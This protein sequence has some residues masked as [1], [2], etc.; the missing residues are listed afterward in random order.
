MQKRREKRETGLTPIGRRL[1]EIEIQNEVS[2][3]QSPTFA[4]KFDGV[5]LVEATESARLDAVKRTQ[6][7]IEAKKTHFKTCNTLGRVWPI[8]PV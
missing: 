4:R 5:D 2:K 3:N 7:Q 6:D 8:T 1:Q